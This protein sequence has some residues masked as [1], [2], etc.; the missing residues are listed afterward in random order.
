MMGSA[1][2]PLSLGIDKDRGRKLHFVGFA[3]RVSKKDVPANDAS[4]FAAAL[5]SVPHDSQGNRSPEFWAKIA[6]RDVP[7]HRNRRRRIGLFHD[8][9]TLR[10]NDV[11][12][13]GQQTD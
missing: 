10:E 8:L 1:I 13:R 6:R 11:W 9:R 7:E 4:L 5:D 2:L 12:V 3:A